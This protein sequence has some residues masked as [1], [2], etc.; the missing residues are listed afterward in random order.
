M[1]RERRNVHGHIG[2]DEF[3]LGL[4]VGNSVLFVV[5]VHG[6]ITNNQ[7]ERAHII[8]SETDDRGRNP[9]VVVEN[10]D[11]RVGAEGMEPGFIALSLDAIDFVFLVGIENVT[12]RVKKRDQRH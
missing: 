12:T 11:W 1:N 4:D 8:L 7:R 2:K 3:V 9:L 10:I 6:R 5:D